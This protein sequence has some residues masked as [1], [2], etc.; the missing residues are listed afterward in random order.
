MVDQNDSII[1]LSTEEATWPMDPSSPASPLVAVADPTPAGHPQQPGDAFPADPHPHPEP[2]LH[3]RRPD[4][5]GVW[6]TAE[7]PKRYSDE[8]A[9]S[10][11]S[12]DGRTLFVNIQARAGMTFEISGPG[13]RIWLGPT[14][15]SVSL[16]AS[17]ASV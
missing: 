10:R 12:R 11:F 2:E 15:R 13:R 9:G 6:A 1:E 16:A 8:F 14:V 4:W 5:S 3:P 17:R 7:L